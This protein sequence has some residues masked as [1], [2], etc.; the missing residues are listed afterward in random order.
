MKL[1][2]ILLLTCPVFAATPDLS[3][4]FR[5]VSTEYQV[6]Y[7]LLSKMADIESNFRPNAKA[8][9]SSAKGLFQV[10]RSTELW[11]RELCD[12]TG[13]VFDPLT[14]TRMG[15]CLI[16]HNKRY[17]TRKM[18]RE[19][20]F[21]ELYLMHFYGGWTGIKFIRLTESKGSEPAF[22]HFRRESRANPK[23]FFKKTGEARKLSEVMELFV[24]K[25]GNARVLEVRE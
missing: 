9:T 14:N 2:L 20:N 15:A 16:N 13:D 23:V 10:I 11:L 4:I 18:K 3:A 7:E 6:S 17:F 19:P 25:M 22:K 12:I 5:Q 24:E 1:L 8:S 21:T